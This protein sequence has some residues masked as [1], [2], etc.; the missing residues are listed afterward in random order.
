MITWAYVAG[1]LDGEGTID[2]RGPRICIY[3]RGSEDLEII[4]QWLR[5]HEVQCAVRC[6]KTSRKTNFLVISQESTLRISGMKNIRRFLREVRP[7]ALFK[8]QKVEDLWR[9]L[10]VYP[11]VDVTTVG[12]LGRAKSGSKYGMGWHGKIKTDPVTGRF[13]KSA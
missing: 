10:T 5:E 13:V 8:K 2:V 12:K 3:Q 11:P 4:G 1:I 6:R 9:F 7:Y